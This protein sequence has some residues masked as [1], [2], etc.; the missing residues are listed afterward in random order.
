[1][2][3]DTNGHVNTRP[4]YSLVEVLDIAKAQKGI[5]WC[6]L[7][8]LILFLPALVLPAIAGIPFIAGLVYTYRLAAALKAR[9]P[10]LYVLAVWV[11]GLNIVLFIVQF[12]RA[13]NAIRRAGFAVGLKGA[14]LKRIEIA[15]M[16]QN[17]QANK[18]SDATSEPAPG[19]DSSA[20]QG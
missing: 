3:I 10:L 13:T 20:H 15:I 2:T 19:A 5:L 17:E 4:Q 8:G 12:Q 11:P 18:A 14:D 9:I 16:M 6:I 7:A 1:M